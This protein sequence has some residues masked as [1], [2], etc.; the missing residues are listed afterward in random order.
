MKIK[1]YDVN[2]EEEEK[3]IGKFWVFKICLIVVLFI[4]NIL[5]KKRKKKKKFR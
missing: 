4:V 5:I 3:I 2:E 1:G